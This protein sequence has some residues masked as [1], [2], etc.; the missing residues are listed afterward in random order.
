MRAGRI[1]PLSLGFGVCVPAAVALGSAVTP[2][3][4]IPSVLLF[5][6]GFFFA[7]P[8]M[9]GTLAALDRHGR[10]VAA[11]GAAM[12]VGA[13]LGPGIG[14]LLAANGSYER[15]GWFAAACAVLCWAL[16]VAV[17]LRIGRAV[18]GEEAR[19]A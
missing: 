6:A 18:A 7:Q 1:A 2:A 9:M 8:F 4:W 3:H 15:L 12:T 17:A 19:L 16:V 10:V 11:A 13:A 14:G 5:A